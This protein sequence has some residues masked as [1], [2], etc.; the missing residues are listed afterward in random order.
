MRLTKTCWVLT[1]LACLFSFSTLAEISQNQYQLGS[2]DRLRVNIF[3]EE[4]LSGIYQVGDDG[5]VAIPLVGGVQ[6]LGLTIYELEEAIKEALEPDF[7]KAPQVSIEV[8]NYRPFYIIG[9]VND[10]GSYPFVSGMTVLEAVALAGGFTY[11][12]RTSKV[13][14]RRAG[15]Q[16]E[17]LIAVTEIVM[18][19]DIIQVRERIF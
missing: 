17:V 18:P 13:Y 7:L 14:I 19:G 4:A 5:V 10:P 8:L 3:G 2:G 6:A 11:R 9:E 15:G 16:E 1:L 12:A